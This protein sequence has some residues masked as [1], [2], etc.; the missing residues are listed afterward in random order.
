MALSLLFFPLACNF[1][2]VVFQGEE[3]TLMLFG[4]TMFYVFAIAAEEKAGCLAGDGH[5][6][7]KQ[8]SL[9]RTMTAVKVAVFLLSIVIWVHFLYAGQVYFK[10]SLQEKAAYSLLTRI[11]ADVEKMPEYVPGVT[12]V[13][14]SGYFERTSYLTE[15]P[16]FE[17]LKPYA[18]GKTSLT[19]Q[20][21]DYA[22]LTFYIGVN[23]NLTRVDPSLEAVQKMPLYPAAE[24]IS[25]VDGTIVVKISD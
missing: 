19:Y 20:G 15:L 24:S 13:A 17:D 16:G 14:I 18:M 10:K 6:P 4:P 2:G 12:P 7:K 11:V 9:C 3:H 23:M 21:T 22:M 5:A 1:V 25:E 8:A